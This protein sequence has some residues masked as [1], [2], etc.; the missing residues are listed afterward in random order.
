M[1]KT[2]L[3][4]TLLLTVALERT[5]SAE[6]PPQWRDYPVDGNHTQRN[7]PVQLQ[8]ELEKAY[9][10]RLSEASRQKANYAGHYVLTTWG[11]G[12]ECSVGAAIDVTTGKVVWFPATICCARNT[13]AN[14]EPVIFHFNSRLIVFSG[15]RNEKEGDDA[16]HF[17]S[18]EGNKFV[19]IADIPRSPP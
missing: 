17:Y 2:L 11:C 6:Q 15:L 3:T 7:A 1:K 4:V 8:T 12:T 9:R 10:T 5:A 19:F 13:D 16:S 18:I 14:F